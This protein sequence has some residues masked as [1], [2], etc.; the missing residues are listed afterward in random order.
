MPRIPNEYLDLFQK[1]SFAHLATV[2]PDGSPQVTPVWV[3]YDGDY[4]VINT[5]RGRV[6]D[7]NMPLGAKV[8]IEIMDADNP[9]RYIQV[10]GHVA[11][12]T[13][14]GAREHIDKLSIKYTGK[15]FGPL[16]PGEVRVIYKIAPDKLDL[17]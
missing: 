17:H 13:E 2:M 15:P 5:A 6:K 7:R 16:R 8:A 1:K 10:R 3:D 11:E 9:Y 14:A 4:V 12:I